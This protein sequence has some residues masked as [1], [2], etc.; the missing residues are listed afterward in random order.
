MS[1]RRNESYPRPIDNGWK[2]VVRGRQETQGTTPETARK[3]A[4]H[5]RAL[6]PQFRDLAN[7]A[8]SLTIGI[9]FRDPKEPDWQSL[10]GLSRKSGQSY[11]RGRRVL[12]GSALHEQDLLVEMLS[13]C[14]EPWE[15]P[16]QLQILMDQAC[17]WS[18]FAIDRPNIHQ[19]LA[20]W[21]LELIR[22]AWRPFPGISAPRQFSRNGMTL[23]IEQYAAPCCGDPIW[24]AF[25]GW[26]GGPS[27]CWSSVLEPNAS[28]ASAYL[29]DLV[30]D[31]LEATYPLAERAATNTGRMAALR[32]LSVREREVYDVIQAHPGM[33]SKE[34][35][36]ALKRRTEESA[37][38]KTIER[39]RS[40][41]VVVHSRGN[42]GYFVDETGLLQPGVGKIDG[43]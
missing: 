40:R 41:G 5:L 37:V 16:H 22:L 34:I 9:V 4:Q 35:A 11:L 17:Q 31:Q 27:R 20:W 32:M 25:K 12:G 14:E 26:I 24:T 39:M 1:A 3:A 13:A 28:I 19:S 15:H 6:G 18:R 30:A 38:R 10:V 36:R 43:A 29:V 42:A 2:C 21:G 8:P 33:L 7:K 23:G